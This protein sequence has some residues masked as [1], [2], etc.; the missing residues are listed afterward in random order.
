MSRKSFEVWCEIH[1]VNCGYIIGQNYNDSA[2][3]TIRKAAKLSGWIVNSNGDSLC[4][5][6][7][8]KLLAEGKELSDV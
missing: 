4:P 3:A 5:Q 2:I 8:E 6:C 7:V 1:C